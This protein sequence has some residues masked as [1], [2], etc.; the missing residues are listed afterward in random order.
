MVPADQSDLFVGRSAE[1]E[2]L[3]GLA[4][5]VA[6]GRGR[7]VW[8][9][10]EPGIGK[11]SLLAVGLSNARRLGCETAWCVADELSQLLPLRLI[12]RSLAVKSSS[13][14]AEIVE[15]ST[16]LQAKAGTLVV[17]R[18][19]PVHAAVE[20]LLAL[21]DRL[22]AQRPLVMVIDNLHWADDASLLAC[23]QLALG[24]EQLPLLLVAACRPVP[25]RAI[26]DRLRASVLAHDGVPI[27][28]GPLE[29]AETGELLAGLL[30]APPGPKLQRLAAR[31]SGN[32]LYL[33]EIVAELQ[34][35][36][37]V[38]VGT[39]RAELTESPDPAVPVSIRSAITGRLGFLSEG[40]LF[41]L[42]TAALLGQEFSVTDLAAV[43]GRR[44]P[45]L[46]DELQ[47]ARAAGVIAEAQAQ[48]QTGTGTGTGLGFRHELIRQALQ[49][50][51]PVTVRAALHRRAAQA[52]S[53]AGAPVEQVAD[54]LVTSAA[55]DPWALA[56]IGE[57]AP[58]LTARSPEMAADL[59]TRA[60]EHVTPGDPHWH[61]IWTSQLDAQFR[62]GRTAEAEA[63]AR[64]LLARPADPVELAEVGWLLARV[65]FS[66]GSNADALSVVER[67]LA[68]P[69]LPLMWRAR[70]H[71]LH[72]VYLRDVLGDLDAAEAAARGAL[73]LG[74]DA[75]DAFAVAS[76]WCVRW[77]VAAV[78]RDYANA[79]E[80]S[81][82]AIEVLGDATEHPEL[83]ASALE[84][85][86]FTLQ[87]LD[88]LA[89]AGAC[90]NEAGRY[91]ER[92]GDPRAALHVGAAVHHYWAGSWDD[93]LAELASVAPDSPEI[94]HF[95]LRE[96]GPILLYHGVSALIAVY[97]DDRTTAGEHLRAGFAAPIDTVS[98]WENAD[99][100][101]AARALDAERSG[102][103]TAA[104]SLLATILDTRPGQMTLV[105]QWPPDL[106]RLAVAAGDTATARAAL[107]RCDVEAAR[108]QV[109]ARA[110]AAA[111]RCQGLLAGDA[112]RL[113]AAADHYGEVGRP[114]EQ[115]Q[116]LED[117]ATLLASQGD[118]DAARVAVKQ[119]ADTYAGL[120][121][122]WCL[123]RAY[124]RLHQ[125]GIR[126][127]VRGR[128]GRPTSGW[129]ALT[130]TE[131][132]IAYLVVDG[133][134][135]PEIAAK[136]YLSR[137]TVRC[138]VS[139]ILTKLGA[140]SRV[141]IAREALSHPPSSATG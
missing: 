94:S 37:Q 135:N 14:G 115:G 39:A 128:R 76:A 8:V 139:H 103:L 120:G 69:G 72:T 108:E 54:H 40:V 133:L 82:K 33:R 38:T 91:A 12:M 59:L 10:G 48:A 122:E 75:G 86:I 36:Q 118:L 58:A 113:E 55:V 80:F 132:A 28:V 84:N 77:T 141:E 114:V 81:G 31:A 67:A 89:D 137:G 63:C 30:G 87:N 88:R 97:R 23:H 20:R 93:A 117:L 1:L 68:D 111:T 53:E 107:D 17:G 101:L 4:R 64:E 50:R 32:P 57:H 49:D 116:A 121:A 70:M 140:Q 45:D 29:T 95:G 18:I 34:R 21:V 56:W 123:H 136:L 60:A 44:P 71:A 138:H 47:E 5:D 100:L 27:S 35:E 105:H 7:A 78:R 131:L 130:P 9:E 85:R 124:A 11:S 15:I 119:A 22:C 126:R 110:T 74:E 98:A 92:T 65:L 41:T 61:S 99:F 79:L 6:G 2:L 134:S 24:V 129:E 73:R 109:P 43:L 19:D 125:Y 90:L 52:L 25:R 16:L 104:V 66:R 51:M 127:G 42:G 96:R 106:V 3:R 112:G 83:R 46:I 26:V 62:L 13:L 102:D